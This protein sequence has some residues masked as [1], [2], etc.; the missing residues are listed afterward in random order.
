M[1]ISRI[2][3][4]EYA[5]EAIEAEKCRAVAAA[6]LGEHKR[7]LAER[8]SLGGMIEALATEPAFAALV[9]EQTEY[10]QRVGELMDVSQNQDDCWEKR[11]YR[12]GFRDAMKFTRRLIND[13][14]SARAELATL[15]ERKKIEEE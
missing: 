9:A 1:G 5:R 4:D 13:G 14:K 15:E 8:S 3:A 7:R 10:Y 11:C 12:E 6:D 2:L